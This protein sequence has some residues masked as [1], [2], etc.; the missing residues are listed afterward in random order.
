MG[1]LRKHWNKE[2]EYA[3]LGLP[4][5]HFWLDNCFGIIVYALKREL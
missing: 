4:K 1:K 2:M 3:H 5:I